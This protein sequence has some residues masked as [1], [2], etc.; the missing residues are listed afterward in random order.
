MLAL[1]ADGEDN[2][3][4]AAALHLSVRTV[5]RHLSNCYAKLGLTGRAARVAAAARLA[6]DTGSGGARDS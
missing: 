2:E 4:I 1:V 3:R 6:R 5:E